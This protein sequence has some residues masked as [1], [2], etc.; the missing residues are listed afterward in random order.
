V[1]LNLEER[2]NIYHLPQR[3]EAVLA[4]ASL[5][6]ARSGI[7]HSSAPMPCRGFSQLNFVG[8]SK[9]GRKGKG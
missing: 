8:F 3:T 4:A 5:P 1:Q 6:E 9:T 2:L 7:R